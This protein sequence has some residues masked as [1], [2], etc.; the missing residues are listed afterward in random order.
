L[1]FLCTL[2]VVLLLWKPEWRSVI[3]PET[4]PRIAVL[5]DASR[6]METLDA[7]VPQLFAPGREIVSRGECTRL[8]LDLSFWSELTWDGR[9]EL[10]VRPFAVPAGNGVPGTDLS[11]PVEEPLENETNL[12]A[13]VLLSDGD[14]SLG[15]PPVV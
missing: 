1:R 3:H 13:V 6:S 7:E 11:Q 12:R 10:F 4:R 14:W 2:L 5:W 15:Q 9:N 8:A